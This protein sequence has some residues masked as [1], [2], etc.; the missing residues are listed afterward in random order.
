MLLDTR[1]VDFS[2]PLKVKNSISAKSLNP[3]NPLIMSFL[4]VLRNCIMNGGRRQESNT[5]LKATTN[6][7]D[8]LH[9][10]GD[11]NLKLI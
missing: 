10:Q 9:S 1:F 4:P 6:I 2:L 3:K 8:P 5:K 11:D 7:L